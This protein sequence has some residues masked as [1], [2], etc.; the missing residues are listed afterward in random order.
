MAYSTPY[1]NQAKVQV[2][3]KGVLTILYRI[4]HTLMTNASL[5]TQILKAVQG[6]KVEQEAQ[7]KAIQSVETKLDLIS[8]QLIPGQAVAFI[9]TADVEGVITEGITTMN[10]QD[11]QKV[12]LSIKPVDKKGNPALLDG[13]PVWLSSNTDLLTV[14]A[15]PDGL[16]ATVTAVGPLGT[17]TISVTGDAD[18]GA[19]VT[20]IAGTLDVT[21]V[22][23][24]AVTVSIEPGTP[25]EQ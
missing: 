20:E 7:G 15:A 10:L 8:E 3:D 11:S 12:V 18:L 22:A 25:T 16:S 6:L 9:F 4:L 14:A 13:A 1:E 19:G 21:V 17:G 24:A 23:G 5:L 2:Y